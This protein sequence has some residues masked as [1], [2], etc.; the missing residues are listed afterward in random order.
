MQPDLKKGM[1]V[2]LWWDQSEA[3]LKATLAEYSSA[4]AWDSQAGFADSSACWTTDW[5][6][7]QTISIPLVA[8]G[9]PMFRLQPNVSGYTR[10][11]IFDALGIGSYA[12]TGNSGAGF[13]PAYAYLM[14]D[15]SQN[16][17]KYAY[18]DYVYTTA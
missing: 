10:W 16:L 8:A 2:W 1:A 4:T 18:W 5:T 13:T 15:G 11:Y 9:A 7:I 3:T 17:Y 6:A 14:T 12:V